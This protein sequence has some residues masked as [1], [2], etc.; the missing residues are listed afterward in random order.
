MTSIMLY[1]AVDSSGTTVSRP[2]ASLSLH[3][4]T[5]THTTACTEWDRNCVQ[6][7][8]V[9]VPTWWHRNT[10]NGMY[11]VRQKLCPDP[12]CPCTYMVTQKHTRRHLQRETETASKPGAS[13]SLNG[14]KETHT[15][16]CTG[17]DRNTA[18]QAVHN[19]IQHSTAQHSTK[20][21][22]HWNTSRQ[23]ASFI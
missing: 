5:E 13:L 11:R 20:Y 1:A 16:A 19:T 23:A 14:N 22:Y 8:S 18:T 4:V 15:T 21:N 7:W 6:T 12:E 10:H 9:P 17:W 2:G 3:G